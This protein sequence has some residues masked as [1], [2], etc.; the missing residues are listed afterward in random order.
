MIWCLIKTYYSLLLAIDLSCTHSI[1]NATLAQSTMAKVVT[2]FKP[3]FLET[4]GESVVVDSSQCLKIIC[5]QSTFPNGDEHVARKAALLR[6]SLGVEGYHIYTS[7][8]A[9]VKENYEDA[10]VHLESHFDRKRSQIFQQALFT[11]RMQ[12][13]G[14]TVSQY[15]ASLR[16]L[17]A[18][19]SFEATQ[20]D[21]CVR[22]QFV[23]CLLDPKIR[24]RLLQEPDK[25]TMEQLVQDNLGKVYEGSTCVK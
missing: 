10:V 14:G 18:K 13:A 9:D 24:E 8:V 12:A 3:S 19:C 4:A 22:D 15:I 5:W 21:E 1:R 25:S 20:L 17:A 7:L 6:A 23:A 11:R 2:P 16:E